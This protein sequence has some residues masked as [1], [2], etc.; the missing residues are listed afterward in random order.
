MCEN[1]QVNSGDGSQQQNEI[2]MYFVWKQK[3]RKKNKWK[4]LSATKAF[5]HFRRSLILVNSYRHTSCTHGRMGYQLADF[6]IFWYSDFFACLFVSVFFYNSGL[7]WFDAVW[8]FV[9]KWMR[10]TNSFWCV[11]KRSVLG[12]CICLRLK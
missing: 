4:T 6:S 7:F 5:A 1:W 2:L 10:T 12:G 11:I 3:Y 8:T 9:T